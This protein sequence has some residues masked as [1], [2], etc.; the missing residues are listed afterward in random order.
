MRNTLPAFYIA[1][2]CFIYIAMRQW[3]SDTK[4]LIFCVV[5]LAAA[6]LIAVGGV[7]FMGYGSTIDFEGGRSIGTFNNPNQLG[8]FSVCLFSLAAALYLRGSISRLIL[9]AFIVTAVFLAIASL[10]K[11]AMVACAFGV[12]SIVYRMSKSKAGILL[13]LLLSAILVL[14]SFFLFTSGQLDDYKFTHRLSSIGSQSDDSL[15]GRG[16]GILLDVDAI[17]LLFGHGSEG[18]S[19]ILGHELHS[20]IGSFF[21]NYGLIGG[22]LFIV[23][24]IFW[25]KKTWNNYGF[26]GLLTIV[27]PPMLYGLTHNGSRFTV[28]WLLLALSTVQL[29]SSVRR[30]KRTL[31][32]DTV[33]LSPAK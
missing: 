10:S 16:Y 3:L 12:L 7:F 15:E 8:Y 22:I 21:A 4:N 30:K 11:A 31:P 20:T 19:K 1:F 2:S 32:G 18:V 6:A 29:P 13:G 28:F 26:T 17:Q 25:F 27:V 24:L 14:A 9:L 23:F 5:G 33:T